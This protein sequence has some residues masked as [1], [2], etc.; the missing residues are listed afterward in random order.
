MTK[1]L[2]LYIFFLLTLLPSVA[3]SLE[4][5]SDRT[6]TSLDYFKKPF[7]RMEN[8]ADIRL[9]FIS[10]ENMQTLSD[11]TPG[12]KWFYQRYRARIWSSINLN[13]TMDFNL[14]IL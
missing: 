8:G 10:A 9:R 3:F 2:I 6:V 12:A 7:S 11:E 4:D 14:G 1:N 5:K 13:E